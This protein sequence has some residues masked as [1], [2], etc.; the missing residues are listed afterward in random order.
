MSGCTNSRGGVENLVR[1]REEERER[2]LERAHEQVVVRK[3][4]M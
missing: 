3:R 4:S 1:E 2:E